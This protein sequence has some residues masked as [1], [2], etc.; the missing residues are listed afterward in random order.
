MAIYGKIGDIIKQ[1]EVKQRIQ[2]GLKYLKC[3]DNSFFV[4]KP[5]GYSIKTNIRG[6]TI[7]AIH[8]VYETKPIRQARYECHRNHIDL[9]YIWAGKELIAIASSGKPTPIVRYNKEKDIEF[10]KYFPSTA[11]IMG[12]GAI[13]ILF[14]SDIHAPGLHFRKR[15]VVRKTVIKVKC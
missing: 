1:V 9:Q 15:Q 4:D 10:F 3:L 5:V 7:V 14:P 11:F 2:A 12:P 13:A 6:N 8:Q